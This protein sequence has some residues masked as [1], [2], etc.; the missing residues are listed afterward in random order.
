LDVPFSVTELTVQ[1]SV[2]PAAVAPGAVVLAATLAVAV[3][4]Q[5]VVESATVSV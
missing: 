2:P 3:L 4:V 1:V 5:P